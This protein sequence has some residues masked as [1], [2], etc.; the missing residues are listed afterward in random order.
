MATTVLKNFL[1][2][3]NTRPIT[4]SAGEM[5][6]YKDWRGQGLWQCETGGNNGI[7]L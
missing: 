1:T 5:W 3:E 2:L 4:K 6:L 7:H